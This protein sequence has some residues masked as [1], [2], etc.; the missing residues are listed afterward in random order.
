MSEGELKI[1]E[2]LN[3]ISE[4]Q[5]AF[6]ERFISLEK[7]VIGHDTHIEQLKSD[8]NKAIGVAW[9]G[10][11]ILAICVFIYELFFKHS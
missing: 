9:L 3:E 2:K 7:T 6:H 8:R 11:G 1:F 4:R 10:S 5:V